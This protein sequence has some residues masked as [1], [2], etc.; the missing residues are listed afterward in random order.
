MDSTEV[1]IEALGAT[2]ASASERLCTAW[3]QLKG[4]VY[5]VETE[6]REVAAALHQLF[7]VLSRWEDVE[8]SLDVPD[9]ER[10]TD[11]GLGLVQEL[12]ATAAL[13]DMGRLGQEIEL[14]AY[15][16]AVWAARRGVPLRVLDPVVN[17]VALLA[18]NA[19]EPEDLERLFKGIS[20]IAEAVDPG[21]RGDLEA[22]GQ[23]RPWR[24]LLLNRAII[25]TRTHQPEIMEAA[26]AAVVQYL[27]DDA[28]RFFA[29]GMEQMELLDY[30]SHVRQVMQRYYDRWGGGRRV[31]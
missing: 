22:S 5:G 6:P 21:I 28:S 24:L 16:F 30:P 15:P 17:A 19:S 29:E 25:A 20:E 14:Q 7:A 12:A 26:F 11:Y 1:D 9:L 13:L 23:G 3:D 27:P 8:E 18:N 31:H 4:P 2:L 10:L